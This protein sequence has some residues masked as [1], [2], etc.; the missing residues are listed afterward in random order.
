MRGESNSKLTRA[1]RFRLE[2]ELYYLAHFDNT[3]LENT[4]YRGKY[5]AGRKPP[6][7]YE[8][9]ICQ[10]LLYTAEQIQRNETAA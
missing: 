10:S 9:M 3:Y 2:K 7:G 1:E 5:Y 6:M 4:A 8:H